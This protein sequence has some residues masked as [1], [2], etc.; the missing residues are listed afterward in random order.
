M[1]NNVAVAIVG[2]IS[3]FMIALLGII[4]TIIN[5]KLNRAEVDRDAATKSTDL[6]LGA[7]HT[8]TNSNW[9]QT[10]EQLAAANNKISALQEMIAELRSPSAGK[11]QLTPLA[12]TIPLPV[13]DV[14]TADAAEK[15]AKA[16][17]RLADATEKKEN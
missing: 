9:T 4:G 6:Q 17:D 8:L 13:Q 12:Q 11:T 1:D 3:T 7:I 16:L 2:A 15:S 5:S 14:R 10:K